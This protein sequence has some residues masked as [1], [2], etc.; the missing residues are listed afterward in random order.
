MT[1]PQDAPTREEVST[2][3]VRFR[4]RLSCGAA[5][6][7]APLLP[8]DDQ[9]EPLPWHAEWM[10]ENGEMDRL[11][12]WRPLTTPQDGHARRLRH[13]AYLFG[14]D[15]RVLALAPSRCIFASDRL[16]LAGIVAP[17]P[18][19]APWD[20]RRWVPYMSALGI[21][22]RAAAWTLQTLYVMPGWE[23]DDRPSLPSPVEFRLSESSS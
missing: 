21:V 18:P 15:G 9:P 4:F 11:T 19:S 12:R 22:L 23:T 14:S 7:R 20:L 6:G 17:T 1:A 2:Q 3:S 16:V 8:W 13:A 5:L 10:R